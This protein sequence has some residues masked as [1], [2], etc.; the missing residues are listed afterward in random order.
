MSYCVYY[1]AAAHRH[2]VWLIVAHLKSHDNIAFHRTMDG[3]RD[4]LEFFVPPSQ[5]ETL[6]TMLT[7]YRDEGLIFSFKKEENRFENCQST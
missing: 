1:V 4:V 7:I 5:E 3:S 2:M 6:V